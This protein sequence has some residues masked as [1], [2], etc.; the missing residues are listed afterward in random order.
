MFASWNSSLPEVFPRLPGGCV[1]IE[2]YDFRAWPKIAP[3]W[4]VI[5]ENSPYLSFYLSEDWTAAWLETYGEIVRP[6][7]IVFTV[8]A[9]PV[10]TCLLVQDSE[11]RGPFRVSRVYLNTGSGMTGDRPFMEFNSL[12]C[13]AGWEEKVASALGDHLQQFEWDEFA[14]EGISDSPILNWIHLKTF[15]ELSASVKVKSSRYVNLDRLRMKEKAY[16]TSLSPNTR[17]QI[18]HSIRRYAALGSI[19]VDVA[20][21]LSTAEKLFEEMKS[22]HQVRWTARGQQGG[23]SPSRKLEFHRA[24]IKRAFLKGTI[25][26]LRVSAGKETIGILYNFTQRGKVYF[27]QSGLNYK[28]DKDAKPGLVTHALAIQHCLDAGFCDYDFLAGDARY[29]RSLARECRTLQWV[30]FSRPGV[31]LAVIELLRAM[32]HR[33]NGSAEHVA[34]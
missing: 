21:D 10:G 2:R 14:I 11:R 3:L 26:L 9:V 5:A 8:D 4:S 17:E 18:R 13:I 19:S 15:P 1:R 7:I 22:M 29:K 16:E 31:R 28:L 6:Q 34:N 27:F 24:L 32:K 25:Q 30:V 33:M 20:S 23:F 12:L